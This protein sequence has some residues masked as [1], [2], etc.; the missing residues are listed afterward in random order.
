MVGPQII[1]AR[2]DSFCGEFNLFEAWASDISTMLKL[3]LSPP[4]TYYYILTL[5]LLDYTPYL[6]K[7]L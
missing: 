5:L 3:H 4:V 2:D 1:L 7:E 6:V